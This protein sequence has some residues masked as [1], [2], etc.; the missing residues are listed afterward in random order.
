M[1]TIS[2]LTQMLCT[3]GENLKISNYDLF[4]KMLFEYENIKK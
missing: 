4:A 1:C 3:S 2:A